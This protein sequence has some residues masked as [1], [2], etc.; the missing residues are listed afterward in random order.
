M[1]YT[2]LRP[3]TRLTLE[4]DLVHYI[5]CLYEMTKHSTLAQNISTR[6]VIAV[7]KADKYTSTVPSKYC[8]R[9]FRDRKEDVN[10]RKTARGCKS[11]IYYQE[12]RDDKWSSDLCKMAGLPRPFGATATE[13]KTP[14]EK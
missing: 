12:K 2:S 7:G 11:M 10:K 8:S 14:F 6:R 3:S 5:S 4:N 13:D 1:S 9:T